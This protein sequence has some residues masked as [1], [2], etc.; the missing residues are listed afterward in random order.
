MKRFITWETVAVD[1][2]PALPRSGEVVLA[3]PAGATTSYSFW[4]TDM[5]PFF[6]LPDG[7]P[8][9]GMHV[10]DLVFDLD[11]ELTAAGEAT[12]APIGEA[13]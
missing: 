5:A 8:D 3:T 7:R 2:C 9:H 1:N 11:A 6:D 13:P 4:Q 10:L 12:T